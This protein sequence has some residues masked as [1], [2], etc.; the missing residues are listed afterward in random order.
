MRDTPKRR[1]AKTKTGNEDHGRSAGLDAQIRTASVL[2]NAHDMR[3]R[4]IS[5]TDD[6]RVMSGIKAGTGDHGSL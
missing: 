6:D 5:V 2:G 4:L 1:R 3:S